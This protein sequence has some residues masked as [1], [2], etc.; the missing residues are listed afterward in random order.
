MVR[1][2]ALLGIDTGSH[3][4]DVLLVQFLRT[5]EVAHANNSRIG[6]IEL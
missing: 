1:M 4:P 2:C 5:L 3:N 6:T